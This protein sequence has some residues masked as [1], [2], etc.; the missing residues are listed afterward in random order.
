MEH[1]FKPGQA[2]RIKTKHKKFNPGENETGRIIGPHEGK[3]L[4]EY[5]PGIGHGYYDPK[6]LEPIEK[7]PGPKLPGQILAVY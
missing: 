4:V 3:Y 7:I 2:V 6:E 1:E 5:D